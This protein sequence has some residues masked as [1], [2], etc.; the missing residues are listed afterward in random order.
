MPY[1]TITVEVDPTI[2]H[3]AAFFELI[4]L[5][6][7]MR[8]NVRAK[9]SGFDVTARPGMTEADLERDYELSRRLENYPQT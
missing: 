3:D 7:R 1:L 6:E 9:V 8:V 4:A 5:A 2:Y